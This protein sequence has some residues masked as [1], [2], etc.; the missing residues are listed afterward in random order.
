MSQVKVGSSSGPRE[1]K[2]LGFGIAEIVG[3]GGFDNTYK[4][5][6][7]SQGGLKMY[8]MDLGRQELSATSLVHFEAPYLHAPL[9]GEILFQVK[10][11]FLSMRFNN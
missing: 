3:E 6:G 8:W 7:H 9:N 11:Y 10:F 2:I 5:R 1:V 4:S